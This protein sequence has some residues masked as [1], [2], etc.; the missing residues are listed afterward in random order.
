M[1]KPVVITLGALAALLLVGLGVLFVQYR[2]ATA[3]LA[4]LRAEDEATRARYGEAI[5]SIAT[6][7][8]SLN[9]I[10]LGDSAVRL[11]PSGFE[12]EAG[13]NGGRSDEVLD[14]ISVIKAGIERTKTRIQEL[15]AQLERS[16]VRVAGLERMIAGLRRDVARKESQ[17][18][19][20]EGRVDSLETQVAG[21][22]TEVRQGRETISAQSQT[23]EEKRRELGTV[24]V[25]IGTKRELTTSGLVE[26]AG[27][28]LGL[29]RTLRPSGTLDETLLTP[30]DTDVQTVVRIPAP[31]ARVLSAQPT[32]SYALE[33]AGEE[34]RLRILDPREFR[35]VRHLVILTT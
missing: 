2:G 34:L 10:V 4:T 28:F 22:T 18:A 3:A 24:F 26:P 11:L 8:D 9:A 25:A 31:R 32:S 21:L 33:P 6:I 14:R 35:K 15:D 19:F 27:G 20:L 12:T 13:L 16:G 7:Q 5:E 17:V 1:R 23:I 29:G 30:V